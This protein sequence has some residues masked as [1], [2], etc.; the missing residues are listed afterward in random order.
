MTKTVFTLLLLTLAGT[1]VPTVFAAPA[2]VVTSVASDSTLYDGK[3]AAAD[4]P[5]VAPWGGGSGSDS[6]EVYL[7]GGHSFKVTT[8]DFYQGAQITF[9]KPVSLSGSNRV[10]QITIRRGGATLHYDPQAIPGVGNNGRGNNGRGYP[11]G[12]GQPTRRRGRGGRN[13]RGGNGGP[14]GPVSETPLIP[15][16]TKLRMHFVLADG[17]QADILRLIPED[18]DAVAGEG[19]YSLNVPVSALKLGTGTAPMLK[20]V[21]LGGDHY[22]VFYV[23]RIKIGTDTPQLA[24]TIDGPASVAPG[25]PVTLRAK[26]DTGLSALSYTW[27]L[28][29][30]SPALDPLTG[31]PAGTTGTEVYTRYLESGQDHTVT[32]TVTDLDGLKK[33]VTVTKTIHVN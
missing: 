17:R 30:D 14:G 19:W 21:T 31:A 28:A 2:L 27:D 25:Q 20:S 9:A 33:T 5:S 6:T 16:I 8:L 7:F 1:A 23:G 15:N 13:G 12:A 22:G 24:I 26:G 11:G 29:S 4:V 3:A 10:F 32:L 18:S